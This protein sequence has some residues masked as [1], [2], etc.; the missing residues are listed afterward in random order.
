MEHGSPD[1]EGTPGI[2]IDVNGSLRDLRLPPDTVLV[3][4]LREELG[5]WG[6]RTGCGIGEC[7][8]CTV[9]VDGVPTRSCTTPLGA[10]AGAAVVTPEGLGTPERPHPVQ[11]AFL[12]EQAAQCGYCV[13]GIIM[14][15]AGL[16]ARDPDPSDDAIQDALVEHI[17]RCGTHARIL[18]AIRRAAGRPQADGTFTRVRSAEAGPEEAAGLPADVRAFPLVEQWIELRPD[19]GVLAHSGKVEIGQGIRTALAQIVASELGLAPQRVRVTSAETGRSPDEGYTAGSASLERG[20][21]ALAA[22]AAAARRLLAE[23]AAAV[24]EARPDELAF[25]DGRVHR[26]D[27]RSVTLA[28]LTAPGPLEGPILEQDRPRWRGGGRGRAAPREDLPLKLTGS[29]AYVHDLALPGM[30]HARA[31]LPPTYGSRLRGLREEAAADVP[32]VV[33][34]QRDGS[35]VMVVGRSTEAAERGVARLA[36]TARWSVAELG[37][38]PE[39]GARRASV[40]VAM[41][42]EMQRQEEAAARTLARSYAK[43][44]EAHAALAPSCAVSVQHEGGVLEVW[45]HSQGV[46]P[47]RRELAAML[48]LDEDGI[49]VR[50]GD[51]PGCYGHNGAD[52][53]AA[54]AALAARALPGTPVRFAF[55]VEDEFA[56]EPYGPAMSARLE[57]GLASDGRIAFWRHAVTSDVHT[58]RPNGDGDRLAAAWLLRGRPFPAWAGVGEPGYRNAVPLY[59]LP[60]LDVRAT[61]ERGPLRTSALRTLGAYLNV[62]AI[63]SFVDE[64]AHAAGRDPVA[65]R[66][67]HLSDPRARAVL[68]AAVEVAGWEPRASPSG[69]GVGVAVARYKGSKAYVAHVVEAE[70]DV[71][72]GRIAARS[73]V[74]A[75]DAGAVVNEDGLRNQIEGGALQ[76]LSRALH[77]EVRFAPEGILTRDWTRYPVL[78]F[79]EAPRIQVVLLDGGGPPLGAGEA[80]TPPLAPAL[81]NAVFDATGIRL[82]ELP[83]TE[84]RVRERLMGMDDEELAAVIL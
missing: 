17:C 41:A 76:G 25:R 10:V 83:F 22:A 9:L 82:R 74:G 39:S 51:G 77:E 6:V 32:G 48:S 69:R 23:R 14:T 73:I 46:Y 49:V 42:G 12:D 33:R 57:A 81:A 72:T 44:Y 7:G 36:R 11:Q 68:E 47:L 24:L 67:A 8:A 78:R 18:R 79:A 45:T 19:G 66:L 43:P 2:T 34:V 64:L 63:E 15:T 20:G 4:A 5:L 80:G 84:R 21:T 3:R 31:L 70:V 16:L 52:D 61:F 40:S 62:F 1:V 27:G 13:N 50:H 53:A 56:W 28:E 37:E 71:Q 75:C 54:F 38:P 30:L 58:A 26:P 35:L 60:A 65:F 29:P 59:D 55:G